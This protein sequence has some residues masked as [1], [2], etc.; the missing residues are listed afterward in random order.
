MGNT[1]DFFT[2]KKFLKELSHGILS[3][4]ETCIKQPGTL[5]QY[6]GTVEC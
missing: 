6:M 3:H 5:L 2:Q 4:S 1:T